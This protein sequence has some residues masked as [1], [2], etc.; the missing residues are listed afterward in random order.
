MFSF[1]VDASCL[2]NMQV[3]LRLP[4][5]DMPLDPAHDHI[6][7][8]QVLAALRHH[9]IGMLLAGLHKLL[10]HGLDRGQ[11]LFN[12][13]FHGPAPLFHIPFDTAAQAYIGVSI[14]KDPDIH[15]I[16]QRL[17]L[18]NQNTLHQDDPV[19]FDFGDCIAAVVAGI[20]IDRTV[21]G[22]ALLQQL[23]MLDRT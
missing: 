16:A 17:I 21:D 20:V 8:H 4:I 14:H 13:R 3:L 22:T 23:Q 11:I 7:R 12:D 19:G 1:H 2:Q 18:K 15:Q 5:I 9:Q 10:M 6:Q